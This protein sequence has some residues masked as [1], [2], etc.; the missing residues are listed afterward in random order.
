MDKET[1]KTENNVTRGGR[2]YST[3]AAI[4]LL[5]AMLIY[6]GGMIMNHRD[7]PGTVPVDNTPTPAPA[8]AVIV[9]GK[10][11]YYTDGWDPEA[12]DE[13]GFG[14]VLGRDEYGLYL[15]AYARQRI[16]PFETAGPAMVLGYKD[17]DTPARLLWAI[18][19]DENGDILRSS[20]DEAAIWPPEPIDENGETVDIALRGPIAFPNELGNQFYAQTLGMEIGELR[21]FTT[22]DAEIAFGSGV[23]KPGQMV[24]WVVLGT[25]D[26]TGYFAELGEFLRWASSVAPPKTHPAYGLLRSWILSR[27]ERLVYPIGGDPLRHPGRQHAW[28]ERRPTRRVAPHY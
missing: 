17:V 8:I 16:G 25:D 2:V 20:I 23:V 10:T 1:P 28:E 7:E 24:K 12:K 4:V 9:D 3:C 21:E 26:L 19:W 5:L 15:A 14:P 13:M 6:C 27:G 22:T 11:E 18:A